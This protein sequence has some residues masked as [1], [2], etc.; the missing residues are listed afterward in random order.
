MKKIVVLNNDDLNDIYS[1]N[2]SRKTIDKIERSYSFSDS[3]L[4]G[5]VPFVYPKGETTFFGDVEIN[6]AEDVRQAII[7]EIEEVGIGVDALIITEVE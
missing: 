5:L 6:K 7:S 2:L 4:C 3:D 1:S